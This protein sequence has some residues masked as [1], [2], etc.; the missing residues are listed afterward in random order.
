M[1]YEELDARVYKFEKWLGRDLDE[2]D[3]RAVHD[4]YLRHDD[5]MMRINEKIKDMTP[6]EQRIALKKILD[7]ENNYGLRH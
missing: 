5:L 3:K 2:S 6:Q 7:E 1:L 4:S